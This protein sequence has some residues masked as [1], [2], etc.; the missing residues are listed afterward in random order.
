MTNW[1]WPL[2]GIQSWVESVVRGVFAA[3]E[4]AGRWVVE[5]VYQKLASVF[6]ELF[7]VFGRVGYDAYNLLLAWTADVPGPWAGVARVFLLPA[8]VTCVL[9]KPVIERLWDIMP[10]WVRSALAFLA[11]L[12]GGAWAALWTF[13]RD[14]V[15]ALKA[16]WDTVTGAL[17]AVAREIVGRVGALGEWLSER[18]R[19][20]G[21]AVGKLYAD[22]T[23]WVK[24]NVLDPVMKGIEDVTK[25]AA[26]VLKGVAEALGQGMKL[27]VTWL[28]EKLLDFAQIAVGA[29]DAAAALT[30]G[31]VLGFV[32]RLVDIVATAVRPASPQRE[33]QVSVM[34][35]VHSLREELERIAK[36]AY[37]SPASPQAILQAAEKVAGAC[38]VAGLA[39]ETA[40]AAGDAAHPLKILQ[41]RSIVRSIA[42]YIG[43]A[44]IASAPARIMTEVGIFTPLRYEYSRIFAPVIPPPGTLTQLIVKN[45]IPAET[46]FS[47]MRMHGYAESWS[48]MMRVAAYSVPGYSELREMLR[49]GFI[50]QG[51]LE[52]AL[53]FQGTRPDF[54]PAYAGLVEAIPSV[55]DFITFYKLNIFNAAALTKYL[56]LHGYKEEWAKMY[57][58][59][60]WVLPNFEQVVTAKVRGRI[61]EG[62]YERWLDVL[63]VRRAPRPGFE[64]ADISVFE[65]AVYRMPSPFVLT[66]AVDSGVITA[67]EVER[68][69]LEGLTHPKYA[70]IIA[71]GVVYRALRDEFTALI[72]EAVRDYA[73]GW[74]GRVELER[75]LREAGVPEATIRYHT[76]RAEA[77]HA[78]ELRE[79]Q[80]RIVRAQLRLGVL[81]E[82][83]ARIR[84]GELGMAEDRIEHTITLA[85]LE[86]S[87]KPRPVELKPDEKIL[88]RA[89]E[90]AGFTADDILWASLAELRELAK[91]LRV[92]WRAIVIVARKVKQLG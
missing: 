23:K 83:E 17:S 90:E 58:Y 18:L 78:R 12:A 67:D 82:D 38:I 87:A 57:E 84:L 34:N 52:E 74:I 35:M 36:E 30:G 8:A 5:N 31:V 69:L 32:R 21:A 43:I 50:A 81:T 26:E 11:D 59:A 10:P 48:E 20:V 29:I 16:G 56:A 88:W 42:T 71:E 65:E 62:D 14:P 70:R 37:K 60:A 28:W 45:L 61:T 47:S 92:P 77:L 22:V 44:A 33:L 55:S 64:R 80:V 76:A 9:I 4:G 72:R 15:G 25:W 63:N 24:E 91:M 53:R 49:R 13:V 1:P 79:E 6:W 85:M 7:P 75:R 19:E 41:L 54:L 73:D 40:G 39:A 27:L 46:Y 68:I 89:I 3:I 86:K 51:Q 66:H 2:D